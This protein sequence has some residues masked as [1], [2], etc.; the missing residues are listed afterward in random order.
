LEMRPTHL[1]RHEL[2]QEFLIHSNLH[3][4]KY[5]KSTPFYKWGALSQK[6]VRCLFRN[7]KYF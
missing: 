5:E 2:A 7:S 3:Y 6:N 1:K 4:R